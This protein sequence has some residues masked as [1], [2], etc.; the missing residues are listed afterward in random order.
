MKDKIIISEEAKETTLRL[1]VEL[2]DQEQFRRADWTTEYLWHKGINLA[3]CAKEIQLAI[4]RAEKRKE[5][6]V[7]TLFLNA[8]EHNMPHSLIRDR[9]KDLA[10]RGSVAIL[11]YPDKPGWWWAWYKSA[12]RWYLISISHDDLDEENVPPNYERWTECVPPLL[13][14]G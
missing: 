10:A 1:H 13:P 7:L 2:Q 5:V 9:I 8:V 12:A 11:D 14:N 3:I 4:T 6:E